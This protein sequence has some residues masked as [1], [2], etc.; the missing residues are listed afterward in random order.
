MSR[1][2]VISKRE[3]GIFWGIFEDEHCL[4]LGA[5][6]IRQSA[7]LGNLYVGRVQHV[8]KNI[9]AAFVEFAPGQTGYLNLKEM[10][11]PI[12]TKKN[13]KGALPVQGDEL[14]VQISGEPVK[15]KGPLLSTAVQLH[16]GELIL[17]RGREYVGISQKIQDPAERDRLR[18]VLAPYCREKKGFIARTQAQGKEEAILVQGAEE[19]QIQYQSVLD[20]AAH[21]KAPAL[22]WETPPGYLRELEESDAPLLTE[23]V[24]DQG[25]IQTQFLQFFT[26]NPQHALPVRL[27]LGEEF[28][29]Y[30]GRLKKALDQALSRKVWL[31][32]G[33]YLVIEPTEALTVIDVNSGKAVTKRGKPE[34]TFLRLN[35][36]AAAEAAAQIRLRNLSGMILIDFI[37]LEMEE[38]RTELLREMRRL[39][40]LDPVKC[41]VVDMTQLQ[42]MELTRRRTRPSIAEQVREVEVSWEEIKGSA[43]KPQRESNLT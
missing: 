25:E 21:A 31:K 28:F 15:K 42:L 29:L 34:E 24:T 10:E 18:R 39:T 3:N 43:G 40:A 33:G 9:Q 37:D 8:V 1:R 30:D 32:S 27:L 12:Y 2:L 41:T 20:H 22:L 38:S 6:S 23:I 11:E 17:A 7:R 5:E 4:K 36:E 13:G 14:V 19:L 35:L 26:E 16:S